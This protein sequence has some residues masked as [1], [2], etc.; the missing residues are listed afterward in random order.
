MTI[1]FVRTILLYILV[2]I[3]MRIMGKRQ[4]SELQ[5]SELVIMLLISD[6]AAI[7][8]QDTGQSLVSGVIPMFTLV[9]VEVVLS[10]W[11]LKN[12]RLRKLICGSPVVVINDGK[13]DQSMMK[14]LRMSTEDLF[15]Q[16]RQVDV[17]DIN[18]VAYAI[19]ETNGKVSIIKKAESQEL[20]ASMMNIPQEKVML[21]MVVVSD[22]EISKSSLK[23]CN[24]NKEWIENT[25]KKE[26]KKLKDIFIMTANAGKKYTIIEKEN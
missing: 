13:I 14:K 2:I 15:E 8:M 17:F 25:L 16:L 23:F 9:A 3:A 18:D 21:D 10:V 26:N 1:A 22:G 20:T 5:T 6:I 24:L 4:I 12:S 7:P 19:V 11:M